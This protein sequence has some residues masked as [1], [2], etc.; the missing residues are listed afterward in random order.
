MA[1]RCPKCGGYVER[2]RDHHGFYLACLTCGWQRDVV[3][4]EALPR[5]DRPPPR[6]PVKRVRAR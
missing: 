4:N 2:C 6:L 3:S 5:L 1:P